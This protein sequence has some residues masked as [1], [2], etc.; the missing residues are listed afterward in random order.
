M[1]APRPKPD[2]ELIGIVWRSRR[3]RGVISWALLAVASL[4][5]APVSLLLLSNRARIVTP[6]TPAPVSQSDLWRAV[7]SP[8]PGCRTV[9]S[10]YATTGASSYC[11]ADASGLSCRCKPEPVEPTKPRP[12][13]YAGDD[14][15]ALA[16]EFERNP[17]IRAVLDEVDEVTAWPPGCTRTVGNSIV[18]GSPL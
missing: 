16:D 12:T 5:V 14:V 4:L 18:C 11:S 8:L 15:E 2:A 7:G 17:V 6:E 1:R 3:W 9:A 10:T 13:S